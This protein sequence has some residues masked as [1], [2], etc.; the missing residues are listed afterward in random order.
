MSKTTTVAQQFTAGSARTL[1]WI[2]LLLLTV[3]AAALG[4]TTSGQINGSV[5]DSSGQVI[6]GATLTLRNEATGEVRGIATNDLGDFT[7][8][9]LVPGTYAV[10]VELDRIQTD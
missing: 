1:L 9:A 3:P 7:F 10:K 8:A 4:Q 2:A 6:V 5:L